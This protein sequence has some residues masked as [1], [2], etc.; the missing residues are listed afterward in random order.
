MHFYLSLQIKN[1]HL[2]WVLFNENVLLNKN[3]E[4]FRGQ[5]GVQDIHILAT[6]LLITHLRYK[7]VNSFHVN[8]FIFV[9]VRYNFIR[10]E[11]KY[12]YEW[13]RDTKLYFY[14][15]INTIV[16]VLHGLVFCIKKDLKCKRRKWMVRLQK[17]ERMC[18]IRLKRTGKIRQKM[19]GKYSFN[20]IF[21][22]YQR[23]MI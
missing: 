7:V 1:P 20:D 8:H 19:M 22:L 12:I 17:T 3:T 11:R 15:Y 21:V 2:F 6:F 23:H 18:Q 14:D 5:K 4:Q 10:I 13:I 16:F 9:N